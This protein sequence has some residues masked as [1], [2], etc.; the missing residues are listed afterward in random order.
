VSTSG[1]GHF[2]NGCGHGTPCGLRLE[3]TGAWVITRLQLAVES[4]ERRRG[5]LGRTSLADGEGLVI[6]PSQGIHTFGMRF[7]IDVLAV[8][9]DGRVLKIRTAVAPRRL[10]LALR[11]WAMVELSAGAAARTG[12]GIG[13][14]LIAAAPADC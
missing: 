2:L 10:V 3:R 6:A 1:R 4:A 13:D 11:A 8:A 7:A 12:V 14:R 9:R 5:L